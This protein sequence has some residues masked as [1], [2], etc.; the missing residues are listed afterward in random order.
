MFLWRGVCSEQTDKYKIGRLLNRR[1]LTADA[2]KSG[3]F[4]DEVSFLER[5][6]SQLRWLAPGALPKR[7]EGYEHCDLKLFPS[8]YFH[9]VTCR[10]F[11]RVA[12]N[13]TDVDTMNKKIDT[14]LE[15]AKEEHKE[16]QCLKV[17]T[18][19]YNATSLIF[20][21]YDLDGGDV[22]YWIT[23][24]L[25]YEN[26]F[27]PFP[28]RGWTSLKR[29]GY[30]EDKFNNLT[31]KQKSR[32]ICEPEFSAYNM[33]HKFF[34]VFGAHIDLQGKSV[35]GL[36]PYKLPQGFCNTTAHNF[37]R[38]DP[39][40]PTDS[41]WGYNPKD[42]RQYFMSQRFETFVI[43][44]MRNERSRNYFAIFGFV[45]LKSIEDERAN[46]AK[47]VRY[48]FLRKYR[49]DLNELH[50]PYM[51]A[52]SGD[53][54]L[55]V[56]GNETARREPSSTT[57]GRKT[58]T[59]TS[60]ELSTVSDAVKNRR[61]SPEPLSEATATPGEGANASVNSE[62][63]HGNEGAHYESSTAMA[64][65]LTMDV[66]SISSNMIN[67]SST[68]N[69]GAATT[70]GKAGDGPNDHYYDDQIQDKY[71]NHREEQNSSAKIHS[72]AVLSY[73]LISI[74]FGY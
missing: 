45:P 54:K 2:F 36:L 52:K 11:A 8:S 29:K 17:K 57:T 53:Y 27:I 30:S 31:T 48:C 62:S 74:A 15:K 50:E 12:M 6:L 61:T 37:V 33:S 38:Y 55:A 63:V 21:K 14:L 35:S 67:E 68:D 70:S 22:A 73:V 16:K 42:N 28:A 1:T 24:N 59:A 65:P 39:L 19:Y 20:L 64:A 58:T 34:S 26:E 18:F 66:I 51:L 72:L 60:A 4:A 43:V 25:G 40:L 47:S 10:G 69:P 9:A 46:K 5:K 56:Q 3:H 49:S 71:G 41:G 23:E 44:S 13:V 32:S 7:Y